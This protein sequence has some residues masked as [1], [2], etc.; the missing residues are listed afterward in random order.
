M[1][2]SGPTVEPGHRAPPALGDCRSEAGGT[3]LAPGR[4]ERPPPTTLEEAYR[5]PW[6]GKGKEGRN[7]SGGR[8]GRNANTEQPHQLFLEPQ[9]AASAGW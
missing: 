3:D 4:V 5:R 6:M 7:E 8:V 1:G 2:R 9:F